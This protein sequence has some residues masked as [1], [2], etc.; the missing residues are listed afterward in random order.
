MS[1][2]KKH[3]AVVTRIDNDICQQPK[4]LPPGTGM[5]FTFERE[6]P[7]FYLVSHNETADQE[8]LGITIYRATLR[9]ADGHCFQNQ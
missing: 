4:L 3:F 2:K 7:K 9:V 6:N 1:K 8:P 5:D